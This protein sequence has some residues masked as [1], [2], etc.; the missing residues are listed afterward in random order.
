[1]TIR[2]G[3]G[4]GDWTRLAGGVDGG[5]SIGG[6]LLVRVGGVGCWYVCSGLGAVRRGHM[7]KQQS[8]PPTQTTRQ[9]EQTRKKLA[10][11]E[12]ATQAAKAQFDADKKAA[13]AAA[14]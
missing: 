9:N 14:L 13:L 2:A 7:F 8:R 1:M 3:G 12:Q 5:W 6:G 11:L 10:E 4:R